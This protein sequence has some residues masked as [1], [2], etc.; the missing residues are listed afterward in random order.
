MEENLKMAREI[1]LTMLPQQYPAFPPSAPPSQS[2]FQFTHLYLPAGTVGGDF[3]AVSPLSENEAGVFICDVAGHGVRSALVTAMIRAL[4]EELKPIATNPGQFLSKLNSDLHAILKHTGT[5]M[6]TT[7]FYLVAD[8]TTG[9]MR[10]ANAGHPKPLHIRRGAGQVEPLANAG[11][12]SQPVLGLF[13]DAAY[14]TSEVKLS[15]KDVVMLFT[16]GLFEVEG[17]NNELYSQAMLVAGVQR[18]AQMPV[19][20]LFDDLLAEIKRFSADSG[21]GDD[22]C[23]VGIE[24]AGPAA[25]SSDPYESGPVN[26]QPQSER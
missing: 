17:R 26:A 9:T 21:F 11:G 25:A 5:P 8:W 4:A 20:Q 2:A 6:L 19:A 16:D 13:E 10:Y 14:Q 15:P 3:F 12:Q 23:M 22:V 7:A 1:Q 24:Y 18:R